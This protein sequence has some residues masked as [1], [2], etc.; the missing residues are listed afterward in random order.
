[1]AVIVFSQLADTVRLSKLTR[2]EIRLCRLRGRRG[3][4]ER[5]VGPGSI[6]RSL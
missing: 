4:V 3:E 5:M 2:L 1:M 6:H